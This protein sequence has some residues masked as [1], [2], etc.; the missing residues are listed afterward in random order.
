MKLSERIRNEFIPGDNIR[1][2]NFLGQLES[3]SQM[4]E[5]LI[6]MMDKKVLCLGRSDSGYDLLEL[7]P[8]PDTI[9]NYISLGCSTPREAIAAA[10]KYYREG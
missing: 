8:G 7:N 2:P 6:E 4:L 1:N 9:A 10:I 5:D 3:D